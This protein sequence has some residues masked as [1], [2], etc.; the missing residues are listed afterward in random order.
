MTETDGTEINGTIKQAVYIGYEIVED[1][2]T[3]NKMG[4]YFTL[5]LPSELVAVNGTVVVQTASY[6]KEFS[7]GGEYHTVSCVTVVGDASKTQV[8]N[9]RSYDP[10]DGT[11]GQGN[12]V[13]YD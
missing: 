4:L 7:Y 1:L 6:R 9:Y 13:A 11:D 10:V 5:D 8:L 2:D 12:S 3:D